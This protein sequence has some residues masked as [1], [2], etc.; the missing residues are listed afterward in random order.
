MKMKMI[1]VAALAF[2]GLTAT[3]QRQEKVVDRVDQRTVQ[4]FDHQDVTKKFKSHLFVDIQGG[5]QYTLGEAKFGDLISPNVQL[6][7]GYQFTPWFAARLQANGWQSKGG[8]NSLQV[9][10]WS[11]GNRL[12]LNSTNY[13]WNYVAPGIDLIFSLTDLIG[14]WNP[15][16][17]FSAAV[18]VGGGVNIAWKNDDAINIDRVAQNIQFNEGK[19]LYNLEYLW[20]GTKVNPFGRAGLQLGFRLSPAV[21]IL[22]EGN[23]NIL[24]DKYNSKKAD[25]PDWY[26]N[27]L[28]GLR[29]NLG[30]AV[31]TETHDVYRDVVVYDTIYKYVTIPEPVKKIEK[32]RRDVFFE[33]NKYEILASESGKIKEVADFLKENPKAKVQ[34]TGYADVQTGNPKINDRLAR[35]RAD[36]VVKALIEQYEIA[37]DRISYDSKGDREQPFAENDKNRVSIMIA[38]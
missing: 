19:P 35:Q 8:W 7:L 12:E 25:N 28:A 1:I 10:N 29:I 34:V 9:T 20:D 38:E 5:A 23:A 6:G 2:V 18:F 27:A 32:V 31:E 22:V 15:E 11:T 36:V 3:A 30:K 13:K 17:F 26:F 16:R 21:S 4:E 14:G 24:T 33:I 37:A